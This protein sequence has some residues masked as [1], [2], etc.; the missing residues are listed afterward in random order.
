MGQGAGAV[1]KQA[2]HPNAY[3]EGPPAALGGTATR[4][5]LQFSK[6]CLQKYTW[7]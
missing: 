2:F 6:M 1:D 3:S 5:C 4:Y 7:L